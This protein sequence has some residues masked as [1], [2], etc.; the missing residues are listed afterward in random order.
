M[1]WDKNDEEAF[2]GRHP[3]ESGGLR[4]DILDE[5]ADHL[6]CATAP[7]PVPVDRAVLKMRRAARCRGTRLRAR[8]LCGYPWPSGVFEIHVLIVC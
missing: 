4:Q 7:A 3:R 2:P 6:A 1:P 8:G 5:I